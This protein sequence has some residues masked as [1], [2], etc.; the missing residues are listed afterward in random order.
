[1]GRRTVGVHGPPSRVRH[2]LNRLA[3]KYK[4]IFPDFTPA[5]CMRVAQENTLKS[6]QEIKRFSLIQFGRYRSAH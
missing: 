1:M 6:L 5:H 2:P 3:S 4:A